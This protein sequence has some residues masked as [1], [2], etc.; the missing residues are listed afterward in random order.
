MFNSISHYNLWVTDQEQALD[1]Y[2]GKLGFEVNTDIQLDFMR[3]LTVNVPGKPEQ[4]IILSAL[5][6]PVVDPGSAE[7]A[8]EL[9]GKGLLGTI[10][11]TTD[12]TR[13]TYEALKTQ[14]VE[15][16]QEPVEQPYGVDCEA[17]DPFGNSIR[18]GTA[19]EPV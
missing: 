2:V 10:I 16:T 7:Q 4:Q 17:R 8:A 1:F 11:L 3:W 12:D 13:A 5:Q 9:L 18:I 6:P 19:R 14:G 15:F